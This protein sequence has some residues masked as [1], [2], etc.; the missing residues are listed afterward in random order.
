M[1]KAR[2]AL[3]TLCAALLLVSM[4]VG[5]TVAYLTSTT[6]VVENTFTV[7]N[8]AI[9]LDE[10]DVD[11]YGAKDSDNRVT[12]NEYKLLPGHEYIKDP[13]VHVT[14]GSEKAYVRMIVTIDHI[15]ELKAACGVAA[16]A[17]FLPQYFVTGWDSATW[18][19]TREIITSNNAST[20]EFWYK[21]PVDAR[22]AQVDLDPLFDTIIMPDTATNTQLEALQDM[23]IT[24]VAH[25]I[26]AD[27]F[28]DAT[29]AWAAWQN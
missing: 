16:D 5:A 27:G 10:T 2:K 7:G 3:L 29:A 14:S 24:I 26:Q 9:T 8:V 21:E 13:Q 22:N 19:S 20:Y 17:D 15:A 23:K 18:I 25:A 12:K 11:L 6:E 1:K 28:A 4:T